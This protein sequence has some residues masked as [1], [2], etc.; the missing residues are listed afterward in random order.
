MRA[1]I[2]VAAPVIGGLQDYASDQTVQV[3]SDVQ[4][5]TLADSIVVAMEDRE[6]L[7][8]RAAAAA[9]M[10]EARYGETVVRRVY[11]E[12]NELLIRSSAL[13]SGPLVASDLDGSD[14]K[15]GFDAR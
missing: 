3:I 14:S 5:Q 1:G 11:R 13:A 2:P 10:V 15:A 7:R 9:R 4:P 12:I 6:A 8:S